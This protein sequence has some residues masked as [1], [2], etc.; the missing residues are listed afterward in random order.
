M[1]A[2]VSPTISEPTYITYHLHPC[3]V[4]EAEIPKLRVRSSLVLSTAAL[5]LAPTAKP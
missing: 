5:G 1:T 2:G 3:E 4:L